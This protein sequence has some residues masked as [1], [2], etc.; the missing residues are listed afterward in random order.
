[1]G[2][3]CESLPGVTSPRVGRHFGL[4]CCR[5]ACG[6]DGQSLCRYSE[7][8]EGPEILQELFEVGCRAHLAWVI[9]ELARLGES[10]R[11]GRLLDCRNTHLYHNPGL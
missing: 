2:I 8:C 1:M 4:L 5:D 11:A 3:R 7:N 9:L 10:E 6:A